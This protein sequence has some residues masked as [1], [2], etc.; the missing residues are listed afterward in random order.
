M[1][2]RHSRLWGAAS[3]NERLARDDKK[4]MP[5]ATGHR[6][7]GVDASLPA[8]TA[9]PP[10]PVFYFHAAT[11]AAPAITRLID[12]FTTRPINRPTVAPSPAF[13]LL[14]ISL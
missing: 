8:A 13:M 11:S 1:R 7:S 10:P 14:P 3:L 9:N 5:A 12:A 6:C 2:N 4:T